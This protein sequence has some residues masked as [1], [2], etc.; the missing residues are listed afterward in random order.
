MGAEIITSL[1]V[2]TNYLSWNFKIQKQI[3]LLAQRLALS[4]NYWT[5][6]K[7]ISFR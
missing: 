5:H 3:L 7:M 2:N 4:I 6:D 1:I